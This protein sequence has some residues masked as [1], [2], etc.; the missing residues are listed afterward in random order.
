MDVG[1]RKD[2]KGL[3]EQESGLS[4]NPEA[5][6]KEKVT[7]GWRPMYL[8]SIGSTGIQVLLANKDWSLNFITGSP[9]SSDRTEVGKVTWRMPSAGYSESRR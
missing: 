1:N 2:Q 9:E 3:A 4:G 6:K 7:V 8:K 5:G